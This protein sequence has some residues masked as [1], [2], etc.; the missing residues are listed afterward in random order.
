MSAQKTKNLTAPEVGLVV[1]TVDPSNNESIGI[2]TAVG[3]INFTIK[4]ITEARGGSWIRQG[5][6]LLTCTWTEFVMTEEQLICAL[7]SGES[8][9]LKI[10]DNML[11]ILTIPTLVRKI[12]NKANLWPIVENQLNGIDNKENIAA[13]TELLTQ[14]DYLERTT[15]LYKKKQDATLHI[16]QL[17]GCSDQ[18]LAEIAPL[19]QS[20][21]KA[22]K[23][24]A[25][26]IKSHTTLVGLIPKL[27]NEDA[28][29]NII[30]RIKNR[31]ALIELRDTYGKKNPHHLGPINLA[32][33]NAV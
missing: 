28:I 12:K 29:T 11:R 16:P 33:F 2:V 3:E 10:P 4:M 15:E 9:D 19:V 24:L 26:Y 30:S 8:G 1:H 7:A 5:I 17:K 13:A 18:Q 6:P 21:I 32:I 20:E 27:N 31:D 14:T 25:S 22:F 23:Q